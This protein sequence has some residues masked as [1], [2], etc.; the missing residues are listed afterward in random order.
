MTHR[1][2]P[3][4]AALL[5]LLSLLSAATIA[6]SGCGEAFTLSGGAGGSGGAAAATTTTTTVSA[7]SASST[8][9]G[10]VMCTTGTE[11]G[12]KE[13]CLKDGCLASIVGICTAAITDVNQYSPVCDCG[14]VTFWNSSFVAGHGKVIHKLD[15]CVASDPIHAKPCAAGCGEGQRCA[16]LK[17]GCGTPATFASCWVV[18]GDCK[19]TTVAERACEGDQKGNC[20]KLCNLITKET[21][22]ILE[23]PI[24][25]P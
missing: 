20:D 17:Q 13:F 11:C 10:T 19:G 25:S 21:P 15:A 1:F 22:F 5:G 4:S 16:N 8:S 14:G 12:A 23:T 9:G 6:A 2:L 18:P 24:C 7:S 3:S